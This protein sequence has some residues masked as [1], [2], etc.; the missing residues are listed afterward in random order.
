MKAVAEKIIRP[1]VD[2]SKDLRFGLETHDGGARQMTVHF[3]SELGHEGQSSWKTFRYE[4][5]RLSWFSLICRSGRWTAA[6]KRIAFV[7]RLDSDFIL[8]ACIDQPCILPRA[9][10]FQQR[11]DIDTG[12]DELKAPHERS[13]DTPALSEGR[14]RNRKRFASPYESPCSARRAPPK[15]KTHRHAPR[16]EGAS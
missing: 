10:F 5:R 7:S 12:T 13:W 4:V 1:F 6:L 8:A 15:T 9:T 16:P 11:S 14:L 3:L 2:M